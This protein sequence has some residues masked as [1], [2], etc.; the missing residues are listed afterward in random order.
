MPRQLLA[1]AENRSIGSCARA[2]NRCG[3]KKRRAQD[4]RHRAGVAHLAVSDGRVQRRPDGEDAEHG[5]VCAFVLQGRGQTGTSPR[6][7]ACA[8]V[9]GVEGVEG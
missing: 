1:C 7:K 8:G 3:S 9:E 4:A 5:F 6:L 2:V